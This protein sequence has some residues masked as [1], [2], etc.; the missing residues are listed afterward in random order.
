LEACG[1]VGVVAEPATTYPVTLPPPAF[2]STEARREALRR[3][4]VEQIWPRIPKEL[5]GVGVGKRE[6][7]EILGNGGDAPRGQSGD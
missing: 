6:Q 7:E 3:Q 4:L 5:L 1:E 2:R